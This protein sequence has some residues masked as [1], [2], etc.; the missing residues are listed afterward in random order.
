VW[1]WDKI[2][3]LCLMIVCGSVV[4]SALFLIQAAFAF[5]TTEGLEFMNVLTYGGRD[6]GRYPYSI[7]GKEVLRFLTFVIPLALFQYYPL[8]YL[9]D[10]ERSTF[11]MLAPLLGL[12]FLIPGYVFFRFGLRHYK[13]TGS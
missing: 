6:H 12:L 2:L 5:F 9:L 1:S 3:T 4:F 8:L 13:S 7:Y 11:Y 10:R